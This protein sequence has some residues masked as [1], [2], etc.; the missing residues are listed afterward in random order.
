MT[1]KYR[2]KKVWTI[3]NAQ[4]H[5]NYI[6]YSMYPAIFEKPYH[7]NYDKHSTFSNT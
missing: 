3:C 5:N 6:V 1:F 4:T 2:H 7:V